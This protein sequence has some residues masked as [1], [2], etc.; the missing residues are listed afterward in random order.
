MYISLITNVF[1]R[2]SIDL[3]AK[4]DAISQYQNVRISN[5][6]FTFS[7]ASKNNR[8]NRYMVCRLY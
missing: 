3:K 2:Y 8:L 5:S 4:L 6:K 1:S 7:N